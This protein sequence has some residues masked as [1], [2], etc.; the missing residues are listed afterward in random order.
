[1]TAHVRNIIQILTLVYTLFYNVNTGF[2]AKENIIQTP[3]AIRGILFC[4][5]IELS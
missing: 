2:T 4:A 5:I 1:M 3:G